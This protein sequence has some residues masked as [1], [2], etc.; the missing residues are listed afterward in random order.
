MEEN[1]AV[2]A[3]THDNPISSEDETQEIMSAAFRSINCLVLTEDQE[4]KK[5]AAGR[6]KTAEEKSR[7]ETGHF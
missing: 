4:L 7:Q 6:G 1:F 3:T 5:L 2:A